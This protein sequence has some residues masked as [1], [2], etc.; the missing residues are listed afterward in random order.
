MDGHHH[1]YLSPK[2]EVRPLPQK[3]SYGVF[4]RDQVAAGELISVWGGRVVNYE[5]LLELPPE[6]QSHSVQVEEGLYLASILPDEPA[7]YINHSCDPNVGIVGH[8]TLCAMRDILPGEEVCFDYAMCDGTPYDEFT[9]Y[10]GSEH[11]RGS[12][13]GTDWMRPELWEKYNGYF[14]PYL[15]RRVE[16]LKAKAQVLA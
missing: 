12:V 13:K 11:C 14:M 6:M 7:D 16:A 4:A 1:S 15:T 9:C 3:G 2:L 10:C 5:Q 8:L